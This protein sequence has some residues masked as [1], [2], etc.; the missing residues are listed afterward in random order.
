MDP[1]MLSDHHPISM[2]LTFP[3]KIN[4][5]YIWKLDPSIL[6]DETNEKVIGEWLTN[7]FTENDTPD[8]SNLY[9]SNTKKD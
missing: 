5:T 9:S 3:D 6:T 2:T 4:N 7:Y 8:T 1:M